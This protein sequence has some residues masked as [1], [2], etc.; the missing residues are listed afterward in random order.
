[1]KIHLSKTAKI[2]SVIVLIGMLAGAAALAFPAVVSAQSGQPGS[3]TPTQA[4]PAQPNQQSAQAK[5]KVI[6]RLEKEYQR[7]QK[8]I[9]TQSTRLGKA[10]AFVGKAQQRIDGLKSQGKDVTLLLTAL[11]NFQQML[12]AAHADHDSAVAILKAHA[13]FDA[14]G[15]VTDIQLARSTVQQAAHLMKQV[16]QDV[17]PSMRDLAQAIRQ[18]VKA[19]RAK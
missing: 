3:Q 7:E 2:V 12:K 11:D 14:N 8:A 1:M 5:Q 9:E 16:Q 10:D 13:G 18:F 15:K 4:A 19:N 6:D 17:R